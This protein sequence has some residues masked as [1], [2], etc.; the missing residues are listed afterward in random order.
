MDVHSPATRSKNMA[1]IRSKDTRPE[2]V[3]RRALHAAG[4]RY[5]LHRKDLPGKPDI[6][7]PRYKTVVF[8]NGCFWHGHTCSDGHL[9]KSNTA[10]WAPKIARNAE[11]DRIHRVALEAAGWAVIVIPECEARNGAEQLTGR[12]QAKPVGQRAVQ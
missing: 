9:P 8:V 11:R 12:L 3:V 2:M 6:V 7:L 1:A 10:Y 4:F 5:R